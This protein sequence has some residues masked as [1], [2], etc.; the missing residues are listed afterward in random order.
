MKFEELYPGVNLETENVEFKGILSE[1]KAE[2]G[3]SLT[4]TW[5]KTIA[6]FANS[7][8]GKLYV[9]VEDKAHK[10]VSLDHEKADKQVLLLQKEI[11]QRLE[12]QIAYKIHP[13]PIKGEET[14]YIIEIV[15]SP[16][17]TKPVF[18]HDRGA[19]L[20]FI[21]NFASTR[22]ATSE[23]MRNLVL[24]SEQISFDSLLTDKKYSETDFTTLQNAA[25]VKTNNKLSIKQLISVG[26][27]DSNLNLSKGALLFGDAYS[28]N[29]T[30]ID[31]SFYPSINKGE[32]LIFAPKTFTGSIVKVIDDATEYIMSHSDT[33]WKK[34]ANG[35]ENIASF[36]ERSLR[37]GISNALCHR[38]YYLTTS[39]IEIDVFVDRLEIVSPGS[40]LGSQKLTKEKN[41]CSIT[42]KR[43]NEVIART[44]EAIHYAENK[45]SGFDLIEEEYHSVNDVH[46]PFI[47]S[48]QNAFSLTLPNLN[49]VKG[50]IDETNDTPDVFVNDVAITERD[51]KI[52]SFC[53]VNRRS[54]A[55][56]AKMLG[57][58]SSTYFRNNVLG[59]LVKGNYLILDE[60]FA[61]PT[62]VSNHNLVKLVE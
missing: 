5:L 36:P 16:S 9:G 4:V 35:R 8:G 62:Y 18:L 31:V 46:K 26:F 56:I 39:I 11:K 21:R 25:F 43:R 50:V 7:D 24:F 45:G 13:L 59:K 30:R 52:L 44:L 27:C 38:N 17:P 19:A 20:V 10:I 6:A 28:S 55:E 23:E 34:T 3:D 48:D 37:E 47:S 58:T 54:S 42:P 12:P 33:V 40:L 60:S 15:V 14:R 22:L 57:L 53:Y 61:Y 2:N 51:L 1:G 41:L 32:R 49:Y 29:L